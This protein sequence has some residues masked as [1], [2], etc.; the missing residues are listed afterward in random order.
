MNGSSPKSQREPMSAEPPAS[1]PEPDADPRAAA[2]IPSSSEPELRLAILGNGAKPRA[3]ELADSILHEL[4]QRRDIVV[5]AV[6]LA[7]ETDLSG[8][9]EQADLGLVL[10]GDGTVLQIAR[11]MGA[12]PIPILGVNQGRLGF[13]T[14]LTS[15]QLSGRW[16]EIANRRWR[17]ERLMTLSCEFIR[18]PRPGAE[19]VSETLRGVNEV[20]IRAAPEFHIMEIGMRVNG[21]SVTNFRGDGVI[22]STP[23]GSTAHSLSAGGPILPQNAEMFVITPICPFTLTQRPLVDTADKV[24]ELMTLNAFNATL[25][26]DGQQQRPVGEGDRVVV[27]RGE[28]PLPMA[29]LAD[30]DFYRTLRNKLGWGVA[31]GMF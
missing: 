7:P 20:V 30:H 18:R 12:R 2:S 28:T 25:V 1:D 22:L 17:V 9:A 27:R 14:D 10:G 26:V 5:V 16:D 19:P 23:A 3:A 6:D 4:R 29:R 8:L 15:E 21:Q 11:R 24:Y 13:L 31:P